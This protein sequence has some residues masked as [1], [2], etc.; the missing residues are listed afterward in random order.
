[1]VSSLLRQFPN[2]AVAESN[3]HNNTVCLRAAIALWVIKI[4]GIGDEYAKQ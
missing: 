2:V 3:E 4:L 1:M